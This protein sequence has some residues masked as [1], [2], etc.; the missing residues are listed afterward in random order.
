MIP[1]PA[2]IRT[3]RLILRRWR[4]ADLAPYAALQSDPRVR[5]FFERPLTVGEAFEDGRRHADGFDR[6]GFD[7]WVLER[8]GEAAFLGVTG[9]RRI[10]RA[11]PFSPLVDVGWLLLPAFWGRGFATEAA[12]A[13]LYDAFARADL[14]EV[15]AY[16]S[17]LNE[18]SQGVMR[19]LGMVRNPADD[20]DHPSQS[21]TSPL[22]RQVLYR[23][24]REAFFRA[25]AAERPHR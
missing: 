6:N 23:L 16:T 4:E 22:R 21:E 14:V 2:E 19:R 8:P 25:A 17:R 7:L 10:G 3:E 1:A 15:V 12:R 11:M 24:T 9:V 18:S 20:F 5:R 13:A